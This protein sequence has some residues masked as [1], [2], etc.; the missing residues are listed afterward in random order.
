[1]IRTTKKEWLFGANMSESRPEKLFGQL[2]LFEG[3]DPKSYDQL[4]KEISDAVAP[5]DILEEILVHDYGH[6]QIEML[7]YRRLKAELIKV[8]AY[9]GLAETLV[10]LVGRSRAETLAEG[11]AAHKSDVVEEVDKILTSAG[12]STDSILAQTFSVKLDDI[13]RMEQLT[14]IAQARRNAVPREIDRHRQTL[15]Q[16]LR[17]V[18]QQLE[19][20]QSRLIESTPIHGKGGPWYMRE[21]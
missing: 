17:R 3:E 14:T 21:K 8:N 10:P 4:L 5:A 18:P 16:R 15:G 13:E 9:K 19:D 1:M 12:L 7:R 6:E 20:N 2:P 11:W